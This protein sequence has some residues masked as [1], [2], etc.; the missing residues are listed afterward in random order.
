MVKH[1]K[2]CNAK[3]LIDA[4]PTFIVKGINTGE[5]QDV[6]QHIPLSELS[7]LIIDTVIDKV[8]AAYG[9]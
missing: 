5:V 7:E 6:P 9:L 4:K 2:V 3:Q 8:N 1:L